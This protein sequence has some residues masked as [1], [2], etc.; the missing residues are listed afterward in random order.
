M[1]IK[2][3]PETE[4]PRERFFLVG[5]EHLSN[6][7]LLAI[8]I[9]TGTKERSVKQI[10]LEV[11]K[12]IGTLSNLKQATFASLTKIKG[13]GK[14]KT[15]ELLASIELG[16][17]IFLE[18]E[19]PLEKMSSPKV[20]WEKMKYLFQ[21]VKQEYFYALYF[22]TKQELIEK[23]LLFIGTIN[24]SIVHPREIFKEAYLNSASS[25]VCIHNHPSGDV[26]PSE[27]DIELTNA[28]VEI[29]KLN[30]IPIVDHIIIST[31]GYYSF[32]EAGKLERK[33]S[34]SIKKR[35]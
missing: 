26:T 13:L 27:K 1:L 31:K 29:G 14:V 16:K 2:D 21:D 33:L 9:K 20:I 15:I 23:K 4:R 22:N 28:L 34:C 6:E 25:I 35:K 18:E 30:N 17:R 10:A 5:V 24:R 8:L 12:E 11:L 3:I 7:E 19:G 32:C